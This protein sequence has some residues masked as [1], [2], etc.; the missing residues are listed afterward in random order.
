[1]QNDDTLIGVIEIIKKFAERRDAVAN[2]TAS[3]RILDELGVSSLNFIDMVLE[4]EE[5]FNVSISDETLKGISTIG[6]CVD[7][8]THAQAVAR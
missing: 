6:D 2:V 3:T 7:A 5:R 4:F 1:M 8:I